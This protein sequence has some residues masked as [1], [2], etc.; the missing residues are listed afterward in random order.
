MS[1]QQEDQLAVAGAVVCEMA[2]TRTIRLDLATTVEMGPLTGAVTRR[3]AVEAGVV[4][5]E[6]ETTH[7]PPTATATAVLVEALQPTLTE[8]AL[9]FPTL[10]V[11]V[12]VA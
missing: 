12:A 5:E 2:Q 10:V 9:R 3:L 8:Q 4:Q 6:S 1:I 7:Q 11:A